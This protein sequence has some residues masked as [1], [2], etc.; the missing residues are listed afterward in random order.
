VAAINRALAVLEG[1]ESHV[2]EFPVWWP[3]V[4][5]TF[6]ERCEYVNVLEWRLSKEA[7]NV[8]A[9]YRSRFGV[10]AVSRRIPESNWKR[11]DLCCQM[12]P[13]DLAVLD[14]GSGRGEFVNLFASINGNVPV[15]SVDANDCSVWFDFAGRIERIYKSIFQLS[16]TESRDVVT[17]FGVIERLPPEQLIEAVGI[18]RSLAKKKLFVAV[19]FMEPLPLSKGHLTRFDTELLDRLFPEARFTVF[20]KSG[21]NP[22]EVSAWI[23]CEMVS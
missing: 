6:R 16:R 11:A 21:R 22:S 1:T 15:S 4:P 3:A 10:E 14:V 7:E 5:A 23:M 8:K 18:L 13:A 20:G 17:C 2:T 9:N 12:V 19:P